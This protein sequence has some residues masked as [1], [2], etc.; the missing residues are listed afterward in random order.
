MMSKALDR[1]VEHN[2]KLPESNEMYNVYPILDDICENYNVL[3]I[4]VHC[5]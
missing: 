4:L 2:S 5:H 3:K 1:A